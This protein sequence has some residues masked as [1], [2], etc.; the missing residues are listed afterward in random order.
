[1]KIA[2]ASLLLIL[3]TSAWS[4]Q[5]PDVGEFDQQRFADAYNRK[6][7][8]AM[9]SAFSAD[10]IRITPSGIFRGREEIRRSFQEAIDLGLHGY[11]VK[12]IQSVRYGDVV[13]GISEWQAELGDR[14]FRGNSSVI[15]GLKDG[16]VQILEETVTVS[17]K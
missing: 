1:M 17:V 8:D 6:D 4:Q 5:S 11:A 2:A 3:S 15:L 9:S 10:A 14:P 13:L 16:K 12:R 7:V